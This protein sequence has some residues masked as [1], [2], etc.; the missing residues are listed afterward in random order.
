MRSTYG[1]DVD[2]GEFFKDFIEELEG[3]D[4]IDHVFQFEGVTLTPEFLEYSGLPHQKYNAV[5]FDLDESHVFVYEIEGM[6]FSSS[7]KCSFSI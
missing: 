6:V 5:A 1:L 2:V 4:E 3:Y 7:I